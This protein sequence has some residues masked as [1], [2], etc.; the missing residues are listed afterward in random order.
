MAVPRVFISST[1]YDLSEVR[2]RLISFFSSLGFETVLSERGDVFYHPD[3]HTHEAC[4]NEISNCHIFVL[5]IGGRFGGKYKI[6]PE[7]SITNA[8]FLAAKEL[9][10]PVFSF[11]KNDVLA[12]HNI[13][14]KNRTKPF[15]QEIDYPSIERQEYSAKIFDFIN[16]VRLSEANNGFFGFSFAKDIEGFLRKQIA[17]MF[18]DF[19]AKRNIGA[20]L[21]KTNQAVN[22]LALVSEKI[23]ELVKGIYRQVDT[24]RADTFI[25]SLD[26]YSTAK[27]L[28]LHIADR[29]SDSKFIHAENAML[30]AEMNLD[31]WASFVQCIEGFNFIA[32]VSTEEGRTTDIIGHEPT[33]SVIADISGDLTKEERELLAQLV[34]Y[35]EAYRSLPVEKRRSLIDE[36]CDMP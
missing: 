32:N 18:F 29:I 27:K 13:F 26:A 1:C 9:G 14:Q 4:V 34:K 33:K 7:K 6:E 28:F 11:I 23:E 22:N 20:Q 10:L 17:G 21:K 25:E 15:A 31:D 24:I 5:I 8:E 3:L 16:N 12:D 30:L 35:Y 36:F 2:D 19:L